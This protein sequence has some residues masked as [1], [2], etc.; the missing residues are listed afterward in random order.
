MISDAWLETG[1]GVLL[2]LV[3]YQLA[4]KSLDAIV[5]VV[6]A[7]RGKPITIKTETSNEDSYREIQGHL[8][9]LLVLIN[10]TLQ[11]VQEPLRTIARD[12]HEVKLKADLHSKQLDRIAHDTAKAVGYKRN[13]GA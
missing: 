7:Q 13:G 10:S 1:V 3:V 6:K 5:A 4:I 9:Q 12:V 2:G 11:A 8:V